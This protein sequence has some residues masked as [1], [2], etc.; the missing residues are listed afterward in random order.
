[1]DFSVSGLGCRSQATWLVIGEP[2]QL[3]GYICLLMHT[4]VLIVCK[5]NS[6]LSK[7]FF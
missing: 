7:H 2:G 5:Y 1:M 3:D 6:N 4:T